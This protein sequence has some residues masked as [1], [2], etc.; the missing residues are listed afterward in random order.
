MGSVVRMVTLGWYTPMFDAF[1]PPKPPTRHGLVTEGMFKRG[2]AWL[3][4]GY[5]A[6]DEYNQ[7]QSRNPATI[8]AYNNKRLHI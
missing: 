1:T 6:G 2:G 8:P 3:L 7:G 5:Q 4:C